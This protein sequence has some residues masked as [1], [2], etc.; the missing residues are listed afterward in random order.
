M[1]CPNCG[2][3]VNSQFCPNC[4]NAIQP[5]PPQSTLEKA[6]AFAAKFNKPK[7]AL[8]CKKCGSGNIEINM[9]QSG[10]EMDTRDKSGLYKMGR[11]LG[12]AASLGMLNAVSG[13][14]VAK[15][16]SKAVTEKRALCKNCGYDWKV[17]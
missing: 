13:K 14:K 2:T 15:T 16:K 1:F 9:M 10:T 7:E 3:E 4:G 8:K 6:T 17:K 11:S 5:P 12:N